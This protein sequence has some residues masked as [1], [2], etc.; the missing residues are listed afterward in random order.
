MKNFIIA[1]MLLLFS[2][3]AFA[4]SKWKRPCEEYVYAHYSIPDGIKYGAYDRLIE[5]CIS[6]KEYDERIK[7]AQEV[8]VLVYRGEL[9]HKAMEESNNIPEEV[10]K[11]CW[12]KIP[13]DDTSI[14]GLETV[15]ACIRAEKLITSP[16][17]SNPAKKALSEAEVDELTKST[18]ALV[19]RS[20]KAKVRS[21]Q[22]IVLQSGKGNMTISQIVAF[23]E[24]L[25]S[26]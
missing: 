11:K 19:E 15:R 17:E 7:S 3:S 10:A 4:D 20:P 2:V 1:A 14:V 5:V 12:D 16:P 22:G 9:F 13:A 18:I 6:T 26:K 25:N 21:C 8:N 23:N 24:C